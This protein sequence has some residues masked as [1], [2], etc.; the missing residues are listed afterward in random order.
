M[1]DNGEIELGGVE[2][3]IRCIMENVIVVFVFVGCILDDV[4]K[5]GVWLDDIWDFWIFNKVYV[6]YFLNGGLVCLIVCLQFMVDVKVE[7]DVVVY[8]LL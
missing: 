5:V 7:I 1:K 3:Q 2:S 4:V 8:K 6:S